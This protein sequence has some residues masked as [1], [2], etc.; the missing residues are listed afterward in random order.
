MT[1]SNYLDNQYDFLIDLLRDQHNN[2]HSLK[3]KWT[4][5]FFDNR[6]I[7]YHADN[8]EREED[9]AKE[10]QEKYN[11]NRII[12]LNEKKENILKNKFDAHELEGE[13]KGAFDQFVENVLAS[14]PIKN[15]SCNQKKK[16]YGLREYKKI[17]KFIHGVFYQSKTMR[18]MSKKLNLEY[19]KCLSYKKKFLNGQLAREIQQGKPKIGRKSVIPLKYA[20]MIE[21]YINMTGGHATLEN[22]REYVSIINRNMKNVSLETFRKFIKKEIQFKRKKVIRLYKDRYDVTNLKRLYAYSA[23]LLIHLDQAVPWIS[24]E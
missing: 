16:V 15:F 14:S 13:M 1:I 12:D 18:Q 23:K 19:R 4:K 8:F 20:T 24:I 11:K 22:I 21:N 2:T 9:R 3:N 6:A 17:V 7:K 10:I 5:T